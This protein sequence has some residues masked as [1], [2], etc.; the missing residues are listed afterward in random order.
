MVENNH[1]YLF[2]QYRTRIRL[3]GKKFS[4]DI[5]RRETNNNRPLDYYK[6]INEQLMGFR[7]DVKV[8]YKDWKYF[9][10]QRDSGSYTA[11]IA[12]TLREAAE[13]DGCVTLW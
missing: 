11:A 3:A 9:Q 4:I 5:T 13:K 8:N 2:T 6:L 12:S 7:K 10:Y 1:I